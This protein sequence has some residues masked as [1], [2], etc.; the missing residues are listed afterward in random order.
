M[1]ST[2]NKVLYCQSGH[3]I[4]GLFLLP[5]SLVMIHLEKCPED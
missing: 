5:S 2:I 1:E 4:G 3:T